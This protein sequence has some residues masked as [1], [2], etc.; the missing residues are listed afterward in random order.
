VGDAPPR[1]AGFSDYYRALDYEDY[2]AYYEPFRLRVF[3]E[4]W[5]WIV[6]RKPRGVALDIGASFGWFLRA[7]PAGWEARGLEPSPEVAARAG[8]QGLDVRAGGI[9]ALEHDPDRYDLITLWNVLEH[10]PD[11]RGALRLIHDRL[12]PGGLLAVCVPNRL[13]LYNRL[14]YAAVTVSGGRVVGP[15]HTLFQVEN[16]APH[17]VHFA[18]RDLR[19]LLGWTGFTVIEIR[20]QPIVDWRRLALRAKLEPRGSLAASRSGRALMTGV[21]GLSRLLR[22]PDEI[23]VYA[24]A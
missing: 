24:S 7:A 6:A 10:L 8:A 18:P 2:V 23:V 21:Y 4:N 19:R 12:K 1:L 20:G 3:A 15:L 9:D 22:M 16:P 17:L 13:G 14:G 11:P 5:R